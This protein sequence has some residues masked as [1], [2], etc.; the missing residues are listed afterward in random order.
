MSAVGR[1]KT[2]RSAG[3]PGARRGTG[4][5][6]QPRGIGRDGRE[7]LLERAA[8]RG[9]QISQTD[10]EPLVRARQVRRARHD[11][12]ARR[13][14]GP[15]AITTGRQPGERAGIADQDRVRRPFGPRQDAQRRRGRGDGR[16]R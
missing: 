5:P 7:R 11:D 8:R 2:T 16:R 14:D 1:R 10:L 3:S 6:E 13:I 9:Q 12:L 15:L 4:R